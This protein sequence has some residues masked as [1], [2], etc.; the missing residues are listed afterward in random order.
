MVT[1][2]ALDVRKLLAKYCRLSLA[3]VEVFSNLLDKEASS[4]DLKWKVLG[5]DVNLTPVQWSK[6]LN[7]KSELDY[8]AS[9]GALDAFETTDRF[10][11]NDLSKPLAIT[12]PNIYQNTIIDM[13]NALKETS[14]ANGFIKYAISE[15]LFKKPNLLHRLRMK[16]WQSAAIDVVVLGKPSDYLQAV[17]AELK[18]E[19]QEGL[20]KIK[21][22]LFLKL[23]Q[24][25]KQGQ[26]RLDIQCQN[27]TD[28]L[29]EMILEELPWPKTERLLEGLNFALETYIKPR[30]F[31]EALALTFDKA[32]DAL[33]PVIDIQF[34]H[35]L[36]QVPKGARDL[37][38][39]YPHGKSGVMLVCVNKQGEL[40]DESMIYPFSPDFSQ[41]DAL[42]HFSKLLTK[43]PIEDIAWLIQAETKK[44]IQTLLQQV[45]ARYFFLKWQLHPISN[46]QAHWFLPVNQ[47]HPRLEH[48]LKACHFVQDPWQFLETVH[49]ELVLHPLFLHLPKDSISK[50]WQDVFKEFLILNA[51]T[52]SEKLTELSQ[53][54]CIAAKLSE[55]KCQQFSQFI[56]KE[57]RLY[58]DAFKSE[59]QSGGL[60]YGLVT[61][62]MSYGFFVDLGD[63]MEGLVHISAIGDCFINDLNYMVVPGDLVVVECLSYDEKQSRLS[64]KLYSA[65]ISSQK[66][67]LREVKS[68]KQER[69]KSKPKAVVMKVPS[70][71]T[72]MELAFAK[73]KQS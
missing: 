16:I 62:V 73:L 41:E 59:L 6:F 17:L 8:F 18:E 21:P 71:P 35:Q 53:K 9:H 20:K 51:A 7:L 28:W 60:F 27:L 42:V 22:L 69:P 49:P 40:L 25:K 10:Y 2:V 23:W 13:E 72:A 57:I 47:K 1:S 11:V 12:M 63:K 38:M 44:K 34:R 64:L 70:A 3:E 61:R 54:L 32:V 39:I 68:I 26:L 52:S 29:S 45:K 5:D 43:Y 19:P 36:L 24:L 30:L 67:P 48:V 31:R 33:L 55:Q 14:D 15:Y 58:Q 66:K 4:T 56:N 37:L 46:R 65:S 50:R